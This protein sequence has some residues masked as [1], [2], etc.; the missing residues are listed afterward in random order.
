MNPPLAIATI[1]LPS[2]GRIGICRLPGITGALLDDVAVIKDWGASYLVTMTGLDEMERAGVADL[3]RQVEAEGV[4][5]RHFPIVDFGA[6]EADVLSSWQALSRELHA[7][8][9]AGQSVLTHCRGGLGRSGMVSLRLLVERGEAPEA[10]LA[11][12]RTVR[13]GAVETKGQQA[14]A[15][16]GTIHPAG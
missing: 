6:P 16:A 4:L 13:P 11:R 2:G 7:A 9:D 14:W 10:A 1:P 12:I 15:S 5:W 3:P 8:L